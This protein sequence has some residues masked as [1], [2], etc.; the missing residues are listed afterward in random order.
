[1]ER[2]LS[3]IL[4]AD[5][6]GYS[7]LI[8]VAEEETILRQK[9]IR[10]EL[11]DPRITEAHGRMVKTMGDGFLVE[12]PS[13]VEAVRAAI[14]V[15]SMIQKREERNAQDRR[16]LYRMGIHVGDLLIDDGDV[17]GDGVN[18]AS[19]LEGIAEP[20]S[21][22]ISATAFEQIAPTLGSLFADVG[23]LNLKNISRP[24]RVYN[25]RDAPAF[26][27][28]P[29]TAKRKPTI[30]LGVFQAI[31]S[32]DDIQVLA[33]GCMHEVAALLA[34]YTGLELIEGATQPDHVASV[35]FRASKG[36]YRSTVKLL[37]N[38]NGETF[39]NTQLAG[40][41]E[42]PFDTQ[43][44]LSAR[45]TEVIRFAVLQR[46]A[47][48]SIGDSN[49]E[50]WL[51]KAAQF[52]MGGNREE[53]AEAEI[54]IHRVTKGQQNNFMAWAMLGC[55]HLWE[56]FYGF[57][58]LSPERGKACLEATQK[59]IQIREQCDFAHSIMGNYHWA[60]TGDVEAAIRST[61]RSLEIT[62]N[63]I[64]AL[65]TLGLLQILRGNP[66]E[67]L[68][69]AYQVADFS[70]RIRFHHRVLQVIA[71]GHL[72]NEEFD[73]AI[74]MAERSLLQ[75]DE[76]VRSMMIIASANGHLGRQDQA[77][78]MNKTI[79]AQHPDYALSNVLDMPFRNPDHWEIFVSGLKLSGIEE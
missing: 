4:A 60:V 18:L 57:G 15:Q 32:G 47:E 5:M 53:W 10:Q 50:A 11:I 42:D 35:V 59:S 73:L 9:A 74:D 16:I 1:M 79:K 25:W 33:D 21:I 39:L 31:G 64:M 78:Q 44:E 20:G 41:I 38:R 68:H 40:R 26:M 52:L 62:P 55:A 66:R 46:E 36:S 24:I 72:V 6:V 14:D 67:G 23:E 76:I 45:I 13:A 51:T 54:L 12:F 77:Q 58:P 75:G 27:P 2:R 8:E 28:V 29:S 37:D 34:N 69:T 19:R 17:F 63:Y 7:R 3:A 70:K 43:D 61:E 30:S 71:L 48:K 49:P 65:T 56:A 22:S